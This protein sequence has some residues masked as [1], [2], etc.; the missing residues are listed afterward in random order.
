M[1]LLFPNDEHAPVVLADGALLVGSAASCAIRLA[2]PGV[3]D[4]HCELVTKA[5][6]TRLRP[7]TDAAATVLNGRQV[8]GEVVIKPGDLVLF[9]RIGC[10]VVASEQRSQ[11]APVQAAAE[12]GDDDAGHTRVRMAMPKYLL[13]GVS[14]PTFGKIYAMV[15]AMSVGRNSDCDICIPIDEISRNHAKLQSA[16]DGVVVEDLASANGTFVNDQRVHA[17][18]LLKAGDEV[19]FDTVRFLLMAPA[20]EMQRASASRV[21]APPAAARS[22]ATALWIIAALVTIVAIALGFLRYRGDI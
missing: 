8:A 1:K 11:P 4:R 13:R 12:A 2:A 5:G 16:S 22:S 19:R 10:R 6:Q 7:L 14:G 17:G 3:A 18:T 15:G 20:E 21:E 9:G